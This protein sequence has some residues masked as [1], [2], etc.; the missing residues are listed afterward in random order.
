ML[1]SCIPCFSLR[2]DV[3]IESINTLITPQ[4]KPG[5]CSLQ[6]TSAPGAPDGFEGKETSPEG[7][8]GPGLCIDSNR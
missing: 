8:V 3:Y 4:G 1:F 7:A 6:T 5:S 2:L